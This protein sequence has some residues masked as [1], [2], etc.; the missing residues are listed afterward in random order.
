MGLLYKGFQ[1][2]AYWSLE[3]GR[4]EGIRIDKQREK[5]MQRI[6]Q[7]KRDKEMN[8]VIGINWANINRV[9]Y[10]ALREEGLPMARR[11]GASNSSAS[12]HYPR[13]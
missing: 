10:E 9:W 1:K 12:L 7:E 11:D 6:R 3:W 8:E 4:E 2:L 5:E 13:S